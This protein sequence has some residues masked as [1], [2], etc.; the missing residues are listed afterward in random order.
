MVK[1]QN[2]SDGSTTKLLVELQD[3]MQVEAVVMT[4]ES[5]SEWREGEW[6]QGGGGRQGGRAA[7][8]LEGRVA[9]GGLGLAGRGCEVGGPGAAVGCLEE[10]RALGSATPG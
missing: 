8:R 6:R 10:L 4:Y 9:R 1:C 3:G 5:P 2:S 7:G